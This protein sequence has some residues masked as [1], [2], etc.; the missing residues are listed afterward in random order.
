[1]T[2]CLSVKSKKDCFHQCSREVFVVPF[3][4]KHS[5]QKKP[6]LFDANKLN[7][8]NSLNDMDPIN[9]E[10]IYYEENGVKTL[11]R[12]VNINKLFT[13]KIYINNKDYQRTLTA[14]T[15]KSL[16]EKNKLIDPFSQIIFPDDVVSNAKTFITKM[17]FK[18]EKLSP[19]MEKKL[20][21]MQLIDKFGEIGFIINFDWIDKLKKPNYICWY[22]E[23]THIWTNLKKDN[24][25]LAL[26][27][28]E[29]QNIPYY[30]N[31]TVDYINIVLKF[32]TMLTEKHTMGCMIVLYGLSWISKDVKSAYPD[33]I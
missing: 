26:L 10:K 27:I 22:N 32:F 31:N 11:C 1:M 24:L 33:L 25:T 4:K 17:K 9:F 23:I 19:K 7:P 8:L 13:Y 16:I 12:G 6:I 30:H 2:R 14:D 5:L 15:I 28:Y 29:E 21:I 18:K 3:C 20:L